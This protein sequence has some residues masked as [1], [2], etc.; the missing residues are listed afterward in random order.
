MPETIA[1]RTKKLLLAVNT[2]LRVRV[3]HAE[4]IDFSY[5]RDMNGD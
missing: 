3:I 1:Q 5:S 2:S 4:N